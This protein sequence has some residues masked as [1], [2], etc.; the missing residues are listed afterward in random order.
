M[1][2]QRPYII[3]ITGG[4]GSGKTFIIQKLEQEFLAGQ[5][6]IIAQDHYYHP[7]SVQPIDVNGEINFDLPI[8]IDHENLLD[9]VNAL[10]NGKSV[11]KK[12]YTFN[13]KEKEP[14]TL[15]FH[16][17]P[18]LIV[19]GLFVHWFKEL[20]R[21]IDLKVFIDADETIRLK[22]R[23]ERDSKERGY[24]PADVHYRFKH[25]IEPSYRKYIEP[26]RATA[27]L[28]IQNN[29]IPDGKMKVLTQIIADKLG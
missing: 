4:S 8:S 26:F 22:R 18:V 24:P 2:A 28:V 6:S 11:L 14:A 5:L 19:E 29:V 25:H 17:A 16:P 15:E 12:E 3:G 21:L 10:I 27:D 13:N 9:D 7:R 20:N 23:L 1:K